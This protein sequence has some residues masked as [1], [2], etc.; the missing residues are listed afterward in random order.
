MDDERRRAPRKE[1]AS[2]VEFVVESGHVMQA[3]GLDLSA[4]GVG[5]ESSEP[6]QVA[7]TVTVDGAEQTHVANL[8]RV[9]AGEDGRYVFGLEFVKKIG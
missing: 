1:I 4:H 7:L 2:Q 5:F 6:L 9:T 8:V 3:H